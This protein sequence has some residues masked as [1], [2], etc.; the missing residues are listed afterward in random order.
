VV[1]LDL[2]RPFTA[3]RA[4]NEG[5][6]HLM[7]VQP[8]TAY[9]QFVDGDCIV[10]EGW[11]TAAAEVLS[12][13]PKVAA[14]CGRRREV[15]PEASI[16]NRLCDMEWDTPVGEA[17]A[18]GGDAMMRAEA[19]K[20]VGGFNPAVIAGEEPELCVRLRAAGWRIQRIE[21]EMTFHDAAM[22]SW[23]QWWRRTLRAGHAYAEGAAMHGALPERHCVREVRSIVFWGAVLPLL[24]LALAWPTWGLSWVALLLIWTA[25]AARIAIGQRS[26]GLSWRDS[27]LYA[28]FTVIGKVAQFMGMAKFWLGRLRGKRS[29]IIEYKRADAAVAEREQSA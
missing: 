11:L 29:G 22:T 10:D 18:C 12:R 3:A 26:R 25:Q 23:G 13:D 5:A 21:H 14:V 16:Y 27:N 17:K 8:A 2:N 19:F 24:A 20:G 7:T 28:V 9:I 6:V 1:P 4:R 15:R